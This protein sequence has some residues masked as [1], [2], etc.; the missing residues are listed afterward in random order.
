M[1]EKKLRICIKNT[2]T[3]LSIGLLLSSKVLAQSYVFVS[4]SMP[5][6]LLR[7]TFNEAYKLNIPV[8]FK[9]LY[10]NDL[11][12][13]MH[14]IYEVLEQDTE[15]LIDPRLFSQYG[16]KVAPALVNSQGSCFDV[17]YG[18]LKLESGLK[19]LKTQGECR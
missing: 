5:D 10:H 11:R 9:G 12:E 13:T 18:N 15:V 1:E 2:L 6:S 14:K 7:A 19:I 17:I 16:I 8:I 4:F 3:A